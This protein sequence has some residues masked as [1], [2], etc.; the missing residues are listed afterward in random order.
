MAKKTPKPESVYAKA[1]ADIT[2]EHRDAYPGWDDDAARFGVRVAD[3][4]AGWIAGSDAEREKR[5]PRKRGK[6]K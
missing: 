4:N 1:D 3:F 6:A 2:N 5:R